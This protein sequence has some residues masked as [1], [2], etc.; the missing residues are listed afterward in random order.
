MDKILI[1]GGG[2]TGLSTAWYLEKN[3]FSDIILLEKSEYAGGKVKTIRKDDFIIEKG[4]D[5]FITAKPALLDLAKELEID[6]QIIQ[7]LTSRFFILNKNKLTETPGGLTGLVPTNILAFFRSDLFSISGK[8]RILAEPFIPSRKSKVDESLGSF[9]KRRLGKE[10]LD[11]YAGPLFS[12]IHSSVPEMISLNAAFPQ[13]KQMELKYGSLSKAILNSKI[14]SAKNT[15]KPVSLF[16]SFKNGMQTITDVLV[17]K[18]EKTKISTGT[19]AKHIKPT[20]NGY[21]VTLGNKDQI[22]CN[23]IIINT[24]AFIASTLVQDLDPN[25]SVLLSSIPYTSTA[26]ANMVFDR[27]QI[28]HPMNGS[29]FVIPQSEN[30]NITSCTWSS[31]KWE[32]RA[33]ANKVLIRCYFGKAGKEAILDNSDENLIKMA[34]KDLQNIIGLEGQAEYSLLSRWN[35]AMPQYQPGHNS[36]IEQ[37]EKLT[38]QLKGIYLAGSAYKGVGLPDCIKQAKETVE[39]IK[40]DLGIW[41]FE[42]LRI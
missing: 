14:N 30:T 27:K 28:R 40:V 16:R 25:L 38:A 1:I 7:A 19:E 37:I 13:L 24:P 31:S 26:V 17:E 23:V 36:K 29:G 35:N 41:G 18:L 39:K 10:M 15:A 9:I 8:L 34:V 32:N 11:K 4:P 21:L 22:A 20:N 5:S 2:I 6:D 33:P 12:G 3:G 42:D